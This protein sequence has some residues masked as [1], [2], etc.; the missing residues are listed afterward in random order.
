MAKIN[1]LTLNFQVKKH[2]K[3]SDK[4]INLTR[5]APLFALQLGLSHPKAVLLPSSRLKSLIPQGVVLLDL[6]LLFLKMGVPR[7]TIV[8]SIPS[9]DL[10][11]M[12][13]GGTP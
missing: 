8:V 6:H 2:P 1:A 11:W 13:T 3:L 7:V 12:M 9:H 10:I 5:L 4:L